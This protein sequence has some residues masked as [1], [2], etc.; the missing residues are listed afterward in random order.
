MVYA[1]P[2]IRMSDNRNRE[3]RV[4]VSES[5]R[6][7]KRGTFVI[8]AKLRRRF[9]LEEG[10]EVIVEE[11]PDGILVR[12]AV[13]VP[14]EFYSDQRKAELLLSNAVDADDYARAIEQVKAMGLDPD[15]IDH[16]RPVGD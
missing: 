10:S 11:T 13:T 9:G 6:V 5:S 16:H 1:Y 2:F 4:A 3:D 14:I 8:P 7:G 12:P 15:R